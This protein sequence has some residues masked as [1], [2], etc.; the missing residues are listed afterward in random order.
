MLRHLL[1]AALLAGL[2]SPTAARAETI[3]LDSLPHVRVGEVTGTRAFVAAAVD[4]GR[5]RVYVCDG[6]G[7]RPATVA[8][9]FTGR[10]GQRTL[11]AGGHV[12]RLTA[13]GSRG[14][15]DGRPFSTRPAEPPAGLFARAD[16]GAWIS[17]GDG[18][19]RGTFVPTR[20]PKCRAVLVGN[21]VTVVC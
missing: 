18:R 19:L 6:T 9:W 3:R 8:Q 14:R 4:E 2:V 12:L 5:V 17:V 7:R 11:R 21:Q 15:F 1:L 20:P 10:V 13:D 16:V